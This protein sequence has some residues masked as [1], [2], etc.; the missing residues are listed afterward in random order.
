MRQLSPKSENVTDP[1]GSLLGDDI[2]HKKRW[3]Q[4]SLMNLG[5][6]EVAPISQNT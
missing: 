4:H 1:Q 3:H 6:A 2:T 5:R